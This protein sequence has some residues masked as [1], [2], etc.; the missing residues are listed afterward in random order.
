MEA[1]RAGDGMSGHV[2]GL[3]FG[4]GHRLIQAIAIGLNSFRRHVHAGRHSGRPGCLAIGAVVILFTSIPVTSLVARDEGPLA[5][6]IE[7]Q[8]R[9]NIEK[10]TKKYNPSL[11][12]WDTEVLHE[13]V[14]GQ[15]H[16]IAQLIKHPENINAAR[17]GTLVAEDFVCQRLRP[18]GL[19]EVFN[20]GTMVVRRADVTPGGAE[21]GVVPAHEGPMGFDTALRN[22][23]SGL[24][25]GGPIRVAIKL[26]RIEKSA[27]FITT[28]MYFEASRRGPAGAIQL[29]ATWRADWSLSQADH[30]GEE[31]KPALRWI[32]IEQFEQVETS[33]RGGVLFSD[34]T[35]SVMGDTP[36]YAQQVLPGISHWLTR[37]TSGVGMSIFGMNGLAVGDVNG[38]GLD[39]LYICDSGGLPNRL[40]VQN[41]DGTVRETSSEAGVDWLDDTTA[42]LFV[43]L[44]NDGDQDLVVATTPALLVAENDGRG[45]FSVRFGDSTFKDGDSL[46]SADYDQDGD[47][48]LHICGYAPHSG[49][50][51]LPAPLPYYDANNGRPNVLLRNEGNFKF[52]DV[53]QETGLDRNNTRFS[54]AAAWEDYDNDG[55]LDL[56]VAN[57]YGRNNLYRN[58]GPDSPRFVEFADTAQ[59]EDTAS[60]M[61]VAWGDYNR[62][63]YMDLYVSNMFSAAGNR[64]TFQPQFTE[65]APGDAAPLVQRMA[66]GN[67][68]FSNIGG[69][70][71]KDVSEEAGVTMGRWAWGSK[72]ADLNNDGY[73]DLV[74][75]NGYVTNED[76]GDL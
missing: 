36:S 67:T 50:G 37:V 22:L 69:N 32:G 4:R 2:F 24:G 38:D 62:D 60:G 23:V 30:S 48:D 65:G 76:T 52:V 66:R 35:Q 28:R 3:R 63:G 12:A 25:D 33:I 1:K 47:L 7:A 8:P 19:R 72:F 44:D 21:R 45:R 64:V 51:G 49:S 53:T 18:T 57:D 40:Y 31:N 68:L 54:F 42:A 20:D 27:P 34:C 14:A 56:Y 41:R 59:A 10:L 71:F 61:S 26:F 15:L 5:V 39:D 43:D 58:N 29:N 9:T 55:D 73:L 6:S 75:T 46:N 13:R 11:D 16:Q 17:T 74:V 70:V